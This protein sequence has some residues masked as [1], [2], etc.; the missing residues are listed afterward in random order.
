MT[1]VLVNGLNNIVQIAR[2]ISRA[3]PSAA[4]CRRCWWRESSIFGCPGSGLTCACHSRNEY[5]PRILAQLGAGPGSSAVGGDRNFPDSGSSIEGNTLQPGILAG[6]DR[7]A[8]DE[9]RDERAYGK[10]RSGWWPSVPF[11]VERNC[12]ACPECDRRSSFRS[13]RTSR[14]RR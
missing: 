7:R 13:R 5:L 14:P 8:I 10:F 12:N 2:R 9:I 3:A 6:L 4:H 1:D 11:R